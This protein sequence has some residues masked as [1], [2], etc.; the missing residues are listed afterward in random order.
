MKYFICFL[1]LLSSLQGDAFEDGIE[2]IHQKDY[3]QAT[4]HF[5]HAAISGNRAALFGEVICEVAL[6]KHELA[7]EH[8]KELSCASCREEEQKPSTPSEI[9]KEQISAYD[10][11]QRVRKVTK[12]LRDLVEK[13]VADTVSGLF[14][15]IQTF[16]RLNPYID[17]LE[18]NGLDCC[19][20]KQS[21]KPCTEPLVE[22]LK[23]WN[24]EGLP[25]NHI[26]K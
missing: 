4:K 13:I 20:N 24:S 7:N 22:Q 19:K 6:G 17:Q 1:I 21:E 11:R 9:E 5:H 16:R 10:C 25:V 14:Q 8:L 26:T 18:R 2:S 3:V 12:D 23:L 15:K